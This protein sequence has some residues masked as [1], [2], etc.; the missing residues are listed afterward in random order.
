[1][2]PH[3]HAA[4]TEV[5][6][7]GGIG[8]RF[9]GISALCDVD[10][11]I[12]S[13]QLCGLIGANGAGKTTLFDVISGIRTPQDGKILM[14][15]RDITRWSPQ[16]RARAGLRRTFQRVQVFGWLS[17]EEN[18]LVAS[19]WRGGGGGVL[20]DLVASPTRRRRER[21]RREK[22]EEIL[23]RCG[24]N[25][26]RDRSAASLPIGTARL[27]ELGRALMGDPT[28]L[29]LDEPASGLDA[30]EAERFAGIVQQVVA[31][32]DAAVLLVEHDV[33][34]VMEHCHRVVVLHLGQVLADGSP[35]EVRADPLVLDAYLGARR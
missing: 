19:E 31:A 29:L 20:A 9:G 22:A 4:S 25:E 10:L 17:V 7:L 15:G 24:L 34:F 14:N 6:A 35:Q 32:G 30:T 12:P 23:R 27:V 3:H 33:G 21:D 26:I 11:T 28:L 2:A 13:G 1:M 5:L 18:L 16:R 8:V